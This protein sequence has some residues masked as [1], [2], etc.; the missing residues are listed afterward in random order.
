MLVSIVGLLLAIR[1]GGT[2]CIEWLALPQRHKA[3]VHFDQSHRL[4]WGMHG[5]IWLSLG[6]DWYWWNIG[7]SLASQDGQHAYQPTSQEQ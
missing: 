7:A 5:Y 1:V 2:G 6:F 3:W 4:D